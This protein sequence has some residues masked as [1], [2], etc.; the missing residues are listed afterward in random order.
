MDYVDAVLGAQGWER[1]ACID[2]YMAGSEIDY[3]APSTSPARDC[4]PHSFRSPQL[5]K[6]CSCQTPSDFS[7]VQTLQGSGEGA[8][9]RAEPTKRSALIGATPRPC[10]SGPN[11]TKYNYMPI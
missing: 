9:N 11:I 8:R 4:A 6:E 7:A 5:S 1:C 3:V 10:L 2:D